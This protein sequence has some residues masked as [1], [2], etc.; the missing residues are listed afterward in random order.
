MYRFYDS[1]DDMG[2]I[3]LSLLKRIARADG[4]CK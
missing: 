2:W 4:S 3:L 1:H